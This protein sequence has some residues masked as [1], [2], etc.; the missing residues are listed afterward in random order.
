MPTGTAFDSLNTYAAPATGGNLAGQSAQ[1]NIAAAGDI[2]SLTT[3][4]QNINNTNNTN[5]VYGGAAMEQQSSQNISNELAGVL[6]NPLVASDQ[7]T[8][9]ER[10]ASGG[11]GVDSANTNA[12]VMRAMNLQSEQLQAQGQQD[13]TSAYNRAAPLVDATQFAATPQLLE[14]QQQAQAQNALQAQAQANA[15]QEWQAQ[16]ASQQAQYTQGQAQQLSEYTQSQQQ[17]GQQFAQNL[18][19]QKDQLAQQ[20]GLSYAQLSQSQ[21][22]FVDSQAQQMT[23]WA[24][25][26][27]AQVQ[28][29]QAQNALAQEAQQAQEQQFAQQQAQQL[30]EFGTTSGQNAASLYAQTYHTLPGYNQYGAFTGQTGAAPTTGTSGATNPNWNSTYHSGLSPGSF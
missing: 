12:A 18:Q 29:Q 19:Q 7:M 5:R 24:G 8:G 1:Q 23:Q 2:G 25:S 10:G 26:L 28:N 21:K 9:A 13:L 17:Q 14:Q 6:T 15:Q 16:L 22:Q 20:M 11:F 3:L 30:G 4:L 27:Q